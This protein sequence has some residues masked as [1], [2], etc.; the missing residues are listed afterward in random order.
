MQ[1]AALSE[2]ANWSAL[3]EGTPF[4]GTCPFC[5]GLSEADGT[6]HP[7]FLKVSSLTFGE[8]NACAKKSPFTERGSRLLFGEVS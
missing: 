4:P 1:M 2:T 6:R 8:E 5:D 7:D 3:M